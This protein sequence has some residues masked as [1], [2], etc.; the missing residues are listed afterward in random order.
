MNYCVAL[1]AKR[2]QGVLHVS[3]FEHLSASAPE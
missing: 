1:P 2:Q 3:F